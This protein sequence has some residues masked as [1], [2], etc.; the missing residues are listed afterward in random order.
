MSVS[1]PHLTMA[2]VV[3]AIVA[4]IGEA[5]PPDVLAGLDSGIRLALQEPDLARR[6]LEAEQA[7][8]FSPMRWGD[9]ADVTALDSLAA[10]LVEVLR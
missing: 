8:V 9:P 4:E 2:R 1:D 10:R 7:A 3:G 5:S 6:F